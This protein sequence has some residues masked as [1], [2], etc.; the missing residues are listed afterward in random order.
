MKVPIL[1][2]Q[3]PELVA[4]QLQL[5]QSRLQSYCTCW[6]PTLTLFTGRF[7]GFFVF[8]SDF[9]VSGGLL[10]AAR[11][12]ETLTSPAKHAQALSLQAQSKPSAS[13]TTGLAMHVVSGPLKSVEEAQ[14]MPGVLSTAHPSSTASFSHWD[15][16]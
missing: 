4:F 3:N 15:A 12:P 10:G 5:K 8:V 14:E 13:S 11:C 16:S 1:T 2:P 7:G 6:F 9:P